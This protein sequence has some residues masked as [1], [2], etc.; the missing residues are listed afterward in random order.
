[1]KYV[2]FSLAFIFTSLSFAQDRV[3]KTCKDA[4]K[5]E[6]EIA[7]SG[8]QPSQFNSE[9]IPKQNDFIERAS[10]RLNEVILDAPFDDSNAYAAVKLL[11]RIAC[12][13]DNTNI[14]AETNAA[15][16][17][18]LYDSNRS[19]VKKQINLLVKSG[20]ITQMRAYAMLEFIGAIE[21]QDRIDK[22]CEDYK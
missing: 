21:S 9:T 8:I 13:Y 6:K 4:L 17:K 14:I 5:L 10:R 2:F 18:S 3:C 15:K 1:M 20:D 19:L 11:S 16:F 7:L 12:F 22:G